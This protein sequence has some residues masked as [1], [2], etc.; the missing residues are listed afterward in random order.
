MKKRKYKRKNR[1]REKVKEENREEDGTEAKRRGTHWVRNGLFWTGFTQQLTPCPALPYLTLP[2]YPSILPCSALFRP[3]LFCLLASAIQLH[4]I[5][6]FLTHTQTSRGLFQNVIT[7]YSHQSNNNNSSIPF[8]L[9]F[10]LMKCQIAHTSHT[11]NTLTIYLTTTTTTKQS[12]RDNSEF[13]YNLF[14]ESEL[15]VTFSFLLFLPRNCCSLFDF[16]TL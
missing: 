7:S 6:H 9:L 2:S 3:A 14:D 16:M 5:L 12:A 13:Y 15:S 10:E 11:L 8:C 4:F 1:E